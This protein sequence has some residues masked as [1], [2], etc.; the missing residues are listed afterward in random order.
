MKHDTF[1][2]I[3]KHVNQFDALMKNENMFDNHRN[4][5]SKYTSELS[6]KGGE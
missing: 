2:R 3:L 5:M 6:W 4:K 1:C